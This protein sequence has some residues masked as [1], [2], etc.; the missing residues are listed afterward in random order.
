M[1]ERIALQDEYEV[2]DDDDD[3]AESAEEQIDDKPD[4]EAV[5]GDLLMIRNF[6]NEFNMLPVDDDEDF[7]ESDADFEGLLQQKIVCIILATIL[8][9]VFC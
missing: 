4:Q 7:T 9:S 2:D 1:T 6:Q 8:G 5:D 3:D